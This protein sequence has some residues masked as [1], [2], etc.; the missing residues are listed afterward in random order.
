MNPQSTIHGTVTP[1]TS[2]LYDLMHSLNLTESELRKRCS[3]E[4]HKMVKRI[5][6]GDKIPAPVVQIQKLHIPLSNEKS[7]AKIAEL[8]TRYWPSA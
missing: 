5:E 1:A 6:S 7:L 8:R 3:D 4:L 2:W